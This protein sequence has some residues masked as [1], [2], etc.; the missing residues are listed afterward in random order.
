[1]MTNRKKAGLISLTCLSAAVIA[2]A[3]SLA[4]FTAQTDSDTAA[5]VGTVDIGLS[6]VTLTNSDNVNP[7]DNDPS[8]GN[9]AN[10]GTAHELIYSVSNLGTKSAKTRQTIILT[11]DES[12]DSTD[13]LD[14]RYLALFDDG[15]ELA[16][17]TYILSTGE[18]FETLEEAD[19]MIENYKSEATAMASSLYIDEYGMI[20]TDGETTYYIGEND[21][22]LSPLPYVAAI[23]YVFYSDSFDGFGL[24]LNEG[25]NAEK[26]NSDDVISA[27]ENTEDSPVTKEYSYDFAMLREAPNKY[28]NA[29]I[30]VD[31]LVEAM[32]Y[33]NTTDEDWS[34]ISQVERTYSAANVNVISVPKENEDAEG[35]EITITRGGTEKSIEAIEDA[36]ETALAD[37]SSES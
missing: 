20:K 16:E 10:E 8:T 30:T 2:G 9:E 19:A 6:E 31:I 12:G 37:D 35:N 7:G 3:A 36:K 28:Q 29:D 33:R 25:G 24:D 26:E 4:L 1:M 22:D 15:A 32:Q 5:K 17:K 14:A 18:E 11:C 23:K 27:S 21:S 34:T 13:L